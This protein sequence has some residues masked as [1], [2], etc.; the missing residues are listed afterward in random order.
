MNLNGL[1]GREADDRDDGA[2]GTG[3]VEC[4]SLHGP[5]PFVLAFSPLP[6]PLAFQLFWAGQLL[7]T[8]QRVFLML[9]LASTALD[10]GE[11]PEVPV[12]GG[13]DLSPLLLS[14]TLRRVASSALPFFPSM[15][16]AG[17][18]ASPFVASL[19]HRRGRGHGGP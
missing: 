1:V 8:M 9:A 15:A 3:E 13:M 2:L 16:Q 12:E 10:L 19:A 17:A 18:P 7:S 6:R 5:L 11:M 14:L 4:L